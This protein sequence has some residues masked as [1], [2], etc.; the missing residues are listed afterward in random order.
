MLQQ[1]VALGKRPHVIVGSPGRLVDHIANTKGFSLKV[2]PTATKPVQPS[3]C[4]WPHSRPVPII[5]THRLI[6]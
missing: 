3:G 6:E 5:P 4:H 2:R 1:A